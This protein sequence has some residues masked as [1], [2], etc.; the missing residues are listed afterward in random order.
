[1]TRFAKKLLY[2]LL[3]TNPFNTTGAWSYS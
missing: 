2:P 3:S 1:M